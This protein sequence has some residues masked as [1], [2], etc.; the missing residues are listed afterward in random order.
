M[1]PA[2]I[3]VEETDSSDFQFWNESGFSKEN[4]DEAAA[5]LEIEKDTK[6][7]NFSEFP[8]SEETNLVEDDSS[9]LIKNENHPVWSF[10]YY[11]QFFDVNTNMVLDNLKNSIFPFP[12]R[13]QNQRYYGGKADLYG[14]VWICATLVVVISVFS[15]LNTVFNHWS[16]DSDSYVYTPQ[17]ERLSI[18]GILVFVYS[19]LVP[20]I[21]YGFIRWKTGPF[22]YKVS[23]FI[24]NY[25]Y[26][27]SLLIPTCMLLLVRNDIFN[28]F[29]V[30]VSV[31]LSGGIL[32]LK[33]W[34]AM[35]HVSKKLSLIILLCVIIL[36]FGL[37]ISI[38]LYFFSHE[39]NPISVNTT[40]SV[41]TTTSV[42]NLI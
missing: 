3:N 16:N 24:S 9:S 11:Q 27:M 1:E 17:F 5:T 23:D 38:K 19:F 30:L 33:L 12:S 22:D 20:T 31:L 25:G 34:N 18:S 39:H 29:L 2:K 28:W 40:T 6:T 36:H 13:Y 7:Y 35:S 4:E 32:C 37:T 14:P 10:A 26:S 41:I 42:T 15:N 21:F 8:D